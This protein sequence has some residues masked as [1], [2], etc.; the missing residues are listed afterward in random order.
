MNFSEHAVFPLNIAQPD[1]HWDAELNAETVTLQ[2]G[3][4]YITA[5]DEILCATLGSCIAACIRDRELGIGGM[6][7]FMLPSFSNGNDISWESTAVSTA[8]RYGAYAMECL[9]N[10]ILKKGGKR[11]NLEFKFFGGGNV[12]NSANKTGETNIRFIKGYMATE[13]YGIAAES[14]GRSYPI[15]LHYFPQTGVARIRKLNHASVS[16]VASE[17]RYTQELE[18]KL[19]GADIEIFDDNLP[20]KRI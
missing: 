20:K 4:L 1:T 12:L 19:G 8:A 3:D 9:I 6:N 18:K 7:H 5:K 14:L 2:P 10:M 16:I 13:G 17:S 11:N 15:K